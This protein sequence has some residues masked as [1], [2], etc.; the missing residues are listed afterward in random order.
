MNI[1]VTGASGLL[2]SKL[3]KILVS[4]GYKVYSTYFGN[5]PEHGIPIKLDVSNE[6][7]VE[8]VFEAS[9]P[10]A[11]VHAAALTNVDACELKR[12][13]AWKTN[14]IG[15]KNIVKLSK[16][17]NAFL[18]YIS[19]DYVFKGDRGMYCEDD[20]PEPI[21]YYGYTKLKGEEEVEGMLKEYCIARTSVIYGSVPASGK[22]NFVL[23]I[24][25]KLRKG[26]PV[27]V[28]LDQ[29]NS[30]THNTNLAE[31]LSEIIEKRITGTYHLAGATKISRYDFAKLVAET[32][33]L[34]KN[35]IMPTTSDK[36]SWTAQRPKDSSL[37]IGKALRILKSKP[38]DIQ[39]SLKR[40]R[41]EM[42]FS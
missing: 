40:L 3:T 38:L 15:T 18:V 32:F 14:V 29:Y 6:N 13:L 42:S 8:N 33:N 4:K 27:N 7:D 21:N 22:A 9:K 5:R 28:V 24:I 35:L 25:E 19:T 36:I 10:E 34:E 11:V 1:L 39:T 37:N 41:H 16:K 12:E 26:E 31:M 17:Y 30:P 2:G 23:W 20:V